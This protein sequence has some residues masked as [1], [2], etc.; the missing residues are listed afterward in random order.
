[1]SCDVAPNQLLDLFFSYCHSH[2]ALL[3]KGLLIDARLFAQG[4]EILDGRLDSI[5][6]VQVSLDDLGGNVAFLVVAQLLAPLGSSSDDELTLLLVQ[7]LRLEA[8]G[9]DE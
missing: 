3:V 5:F 9:S 2:A 1:M 8:I 7:I 4:A 6:I